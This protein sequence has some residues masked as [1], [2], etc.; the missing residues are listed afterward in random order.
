ME[1][2]RVVGGYGGRAPG[3]LVICLAGMH[4]NEPAGVFAVQR[5]LRGLR[6]IQPAFRGELLALSGNR[7]ALARRCRY[8]AQD[9]N[10]V[11]TAARIAALHASALWIPQS[12][13]DAEQQELLATLETAIA[14]RQGPV[15]FLDLHTTSA[16]GV[17]FTVIGDTIPNRTLALSLPAP[18]IL[19][20]EEY[21]DGTLLN[22]IND[23][24]YSAV[25]FEG[26]HNDAPASI[27]HHEVAIWTILLTAGCVRR[28]EIPAVEA[29]H[30]QLRE[31]TR[32]APR[33][34]ELRHRHALCEGDNFVMEPGFRNFQWVDRGQVL[35][36]DRYGAIRAPEA[37]FILMPLYQSQG[38][39][40]FFLVRAVAP[41]WLHVA[42]GLRRLRLDRILPWLPGMRR[43][44]TQPETFLV[45]PR[46]ARWFVIEL[47][48]LLGFRRQ[49][50]EGEYLVVSRRLHEGYAFKEW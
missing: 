23:C 42:A 13:E 28:R 7:A 12:P 41:R 2:P 50:P 46:I 6:S 21:L 37:G 27:D 5:V 16:E 4:G 29:L 43:H 9:L 1:I 33:V 18:V 17:P 31:R 14:H 32:T 11:W 19:G 35:A 26:G 38:T 45:N 39:D 15:V 49:R 36:R 10:R 44:P 47:L 24:G 20:L 3:P 48:H 34:V 30:A 8:L 25:G 40:G 22:Y